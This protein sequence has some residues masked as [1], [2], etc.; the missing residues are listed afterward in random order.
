MNTTITTVEELLAHAHALESEAVERYEELAEQMEVHNNP[1]LAELFHKMATIERKH[2]D[3]VDHITGGRQLPRLAPW[4]YRWQDPEAPETV[5]VG[6]GHYQMGAYQALSLAIAC[7]EKAY[8]FFASLAH[9]HQDPL[10]H[11]LAVQLAEEEKHHIELLR[12]WQIRYP[13][14]GADW[15]T[16]LDEPVSQE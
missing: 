7:E 4:D 2:V 6:Q 9:Q 8:A 15:Q 5:P 13:E 11:T 16:D 3:K 12:Q 1:E 10:V 14:P